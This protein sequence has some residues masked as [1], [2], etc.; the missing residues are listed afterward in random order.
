M[1]VVQRKV[2]A[3]R[4]NSNQASHQSR[5][6]NSARGSSDAPPVAAPTSTTEEF[7]YSQPSQE[8]DD[9]RGRENEA[10]SGGSSVAHQHLGKKPRRS[11]AREFS[12]AREG[13]PT[14]IADPM[15]HRIAMMD[16]LSSQLDKQATTFN[17]MHEEIVGK[18]RPRL[19]RP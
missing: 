10:I 18:D 11:A 16:K 1:P 13:L 4:Q 9:M 8:D 12:P 19:R 14:P 6:A 7:H 2:M 15:A 5:G 3:A 17:K